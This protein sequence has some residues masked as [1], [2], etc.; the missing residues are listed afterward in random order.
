MRGKIYSNRLDILMAVHVCNTMLIPQIELAGRFASFTDKVL[1]EWNSQLIGTILAASGEYSGKNLSRTGFNQVTGLIHPRD[2]IVSARIMD[3]ANRLTAVN[4]LDARTMWARLRAFDRKQR[5]PSDILQAAFTTKRK[6]S[7]SNRILRSIHLMQ[8]LELRAEVFEEPWWNKQVKV[9]EEKKRM[10]DWEPKWSPY[11]SRYQLWQNSEVSAIDAFTDGSTLPGVPEPSGIGIVLK[12]AVGGET[13]LEVAEVCKASGNNHL[14]E[15]IAMLG[16]VQLTPA[17]VDLN[18]YTDSA[19]AI[20]AVKGFDKLSPGRRMRLGSRPVVI[21][22]AR[23]IAARSGATTIRHI[24]SHTGDTSYRSQDNACADQLA[25][26]AR[27]HGRDALLQPMLEGEEKVVF[28]AEKTRHVIG[29]LRAEIRRLLAK[30]N[31]EEWKAQP[32]QGRVARR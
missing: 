24:R 27:E 4:R 29:D 14:A 12:N 15:C 26:D 13:V 6:R 16:A 30:R 23:L 8:G 2:A 9:D 18:I 10:V 25:N 17:Q 3:V 11:Y 1:D 31:L 5:K 20:W 7:A 32:H 22:L 28:W 21:A 19:A